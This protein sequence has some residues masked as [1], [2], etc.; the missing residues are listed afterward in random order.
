MTE[1]QMI[2]RNQVM[3][4]RAVE[5]IGKAA[6]PD[7][8]LQ[9]ALVRLMKG[10]VARRVLD[11][12]TDL[13]HV[14]RMG[15]GDPIKALDKLLDLVEPGNGLRQ[16]Q[17][18]SRFAWVFG[19]ANTEHADHCLTKLI[20]F[21]RIRRQA[22]KRL[23]T[24]PKWS[25]RARALALQDALKA[26]QHCEVLL[27]YIDDNEREAQALEREHNAQNAAAAAARLEKDPLQQQDDAENLQLANETLTKLRNLKS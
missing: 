10:D 22:A 21:T 5:L 23:K 1:W 24:L 25:L 8:T 11:R 16:L 17:V 26:S 19:R 13:P 7:E 3:S 4:I 9:Q 6:L 12:V 20:E 2:P 14:L 27:D 15:D 18:W